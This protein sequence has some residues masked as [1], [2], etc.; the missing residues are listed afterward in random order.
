MLSII[1]V[2]WAPC[3]VLGKFE[4]TWSSWL[5]L[6]EIDFQTTQMLQWN[7]LQSKEFPPWLISSPIGSQGSS[8]KLQCLLCAFQ[9]RPNSGAGGVWFLFNKKE[10]HLPILHPLCT[11]LLTSKPIIQIRKFQ[12]P[13]FPEVIFYGCFQVSSSPRR[14][15][16]QQNRSPNY[17]F[18]LP[19]VSVAS[20]GCTFITKLFQFS[21]E[22]RK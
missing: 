19:C 3:K 14:C 2:L 8:S 11:L 16:L 18:S 20:L 9:K 21:W 7:F 5:S 6:R 13:E 15:A 22:K 12:K 10:N 4:M 17:T 1:N